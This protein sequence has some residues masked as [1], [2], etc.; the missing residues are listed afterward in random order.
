MVPKMAKQKFYTKKYLK[1]KLSDLLYEKNGKRPKSKTDWG[2]YLN[3]FYPINDI[4]GTDNYELGNLALVFY[5]LA[6]VIRND[7]D[8][9]SEKIGFVKMEWELGW[10]NDVVSQYK[11]FDELI[12][13]LFDETQSIFGL[14][15]KERNNFFKNI[16]NNIIEPNAWNSFIYFTL[17]MFLIFIFL[18]VFVYAPV[19]ALFDLIGIANQTLEE[20]F[21]IVL[22][23]GYLYFIFVREKKN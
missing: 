14:P 2:D 13:Y 18:K 17:G 19:E 12:D 15:L 21:A 3:E 7:F 8:T 23:F 22:L 4:Y 1:K 16:R 9:S 5:K 11:T 6:R 20:V 10:G